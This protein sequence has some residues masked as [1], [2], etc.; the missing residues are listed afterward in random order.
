MGVI[1][2]VDYK[3]NKRN[4]FEGDGTALCLF[5]LLLFFLSFPFFCILGPHLR[6]LEVPRLGVKSELQLPSY[7]TATAMQAYMPHLQATSATY[8][9]AHSSIESLTH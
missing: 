4:F 5:L 2:E 8:T 6:H 9:T 1:G 7:T 3:V